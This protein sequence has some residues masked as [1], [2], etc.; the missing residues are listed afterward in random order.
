MAGFEG[1]AQV[2]ARIGLESL[3]EFDVHVRHATRRVDE[4]FSRGVLA[5]RFQQFSYETLDAW[6]VNHG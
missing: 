1:D 5:D 2:L 3:E 4:A 6:V